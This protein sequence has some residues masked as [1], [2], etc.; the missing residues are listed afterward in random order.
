MT[1]YVGCKVNRDNTDGVCG[2]LRFTQPF[3]IQSFKDEFDLQKGKAP[4]ASGEPGQILKRGDSD[5][6]M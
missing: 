4:L 2:S 5:D 6:E 3:M 1:E